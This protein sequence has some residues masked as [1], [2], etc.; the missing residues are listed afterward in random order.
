MYHILAFVISL[1]IFYQHGIDG[2][3]AAKPDNDVHIHLNMGREKTQQVKQSTGGGDQVRITSSHTTPETGSDYASKPCTCSSSK[4]LVP[5]CGVNGKT[6]GNQCELHCAKVEI[7]CYEKCPCKGLCSSNSDCELTEKCSFHSS[8]FGQCT[9]NEE[10][11]DEFGQPKPLGYNTEHQCHVYKG[12]GYLTDKQ[13]HYAEYEHDSDEDY[14]DE[15]YRFVDG[16]N[17]CPKEGKRGKFMGS[18][19]EDVAGFFNTTNH[20]KCYQSILQKE[21]EKNNTSIAKSYIRHLVWLVNDAFTGEQFD[22]LE[23]GTI[24]DGE[25]ELNFQ[26]LKPII[27]QAKQYD[28]CEQKYFWHKLWFLEL[29]NM[30]Y[31]LLEGGKPWS[32][33]KDPIRPKDEYELYEITK[34]CSVKICE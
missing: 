3:P 16:E 21:L 2:I 18:K 12:S 13:A 24:F 15:D 34:W 6:Y 29:C 5:L 32:K 23:R 20:N 26:E 27:S 25:H 4:E 31:L 33:C 28:R 8:R 17:K 14:E 1:M 30:K 7:K 9:H 22:H 19:A 11:F 10:D